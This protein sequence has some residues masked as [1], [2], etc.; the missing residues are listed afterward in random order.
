M[1]QMIGNTTFR[2]QNVALLG[3]EEAVAPV[4]VTS[5]E[6]DAELD[7]VLKRLGL[8]HGLLERVAGVQIGR[9]HV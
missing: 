1:N 5:S 3:I 2:H 8:P 4:E 6:L 9:A 7:D